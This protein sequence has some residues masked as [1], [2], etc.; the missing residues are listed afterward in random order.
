METLHLK[1]K[2]KEN[3]FDYIQEERGEIDSGKSRLIDLEELDKEVEKIIS[4]T[5]SI[6]N[7]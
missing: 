4:P 7:P 5:I 6:P 3:S 2:D 1:V